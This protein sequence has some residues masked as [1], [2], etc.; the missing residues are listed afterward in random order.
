M[1]LGSVVQKDPAAGRHEQIA[2]VLQY[3]LRKLA[4]SAVYAMLAR[5]HID[6]PNPQATCPSPSLAS[7]S[8]SLIRS[9][10]FLCLN[11]SGVLFS[12]ITILY[13]CHVRDKLLSG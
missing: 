5:K 10:G 2:H 9:Y 3:V 13:S 1:G 4:S 12:A 11:L 7:I 8:C 6:I